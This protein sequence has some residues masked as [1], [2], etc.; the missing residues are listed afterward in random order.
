MEIK[1]IPGSFD[2]RKPTATVVKN[3]SRDD[4][5]FVH[6]MTYGT[7]DKFTEGFR[8]MLNIHNVLEGAPKHKILK[9]L[10]ALERFFSLNIC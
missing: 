1:I 9:T 4:P 5:N 2:S 6:Q 10:F 8:T 3:F 7:P